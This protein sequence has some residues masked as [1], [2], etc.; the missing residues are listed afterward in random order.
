MPAE[1][2]AVGVGLG[3]AVGVGL[4]DAA[5]AAFRMLTCSMFV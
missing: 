1:G 2:A 4:G 5:G 3:V